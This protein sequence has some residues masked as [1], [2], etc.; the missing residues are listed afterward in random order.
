MFNTGKIASNLCYQ[1][2]NHEYEKYCTEMADNDNLPQDPQVTGHM[3]F[4]VGSEHTA[5]LQ[6]NKFESLHEATK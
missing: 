5:G 1:Q 3:D 4:N 2:Y 6:L